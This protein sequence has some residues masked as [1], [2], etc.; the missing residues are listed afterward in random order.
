M[1]LY[2]VSG[3]KTF[4]GVATAVVVA[5]GLLGCA[6]LLRGDLLAQEREPRTT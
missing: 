1:P 2:T 3:V 4:G 6:V 5:L